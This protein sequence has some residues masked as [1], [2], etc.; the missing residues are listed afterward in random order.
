ME[1]PPLPSLYPPSRRPFGFEILLR[2]A[3]GEVGPGGER[4]L[5]YLTGVVR[6]EG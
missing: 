6:L 4:L 1:Q 3:T 5:S 2:D